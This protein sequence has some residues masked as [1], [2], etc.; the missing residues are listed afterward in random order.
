LLHDAAQ[1]R[2]KY[3]IP[4]TIGCVDGTHVGCT[5]KE[6]EHLYIN[7]KNFHSINVQVR[8]KNNRL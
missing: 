5:P 4:A 7:R 6:E 3:D 8:K 2:Q 1:F